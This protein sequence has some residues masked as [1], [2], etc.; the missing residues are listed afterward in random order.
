MGASSTLLDP[1]EGVVTELMPYVNGDA[2]AH[3]HGDVI[4]KEYDT[5]AHSYA[6]YGVKSPASANSTKLMG[7]VWDPMG[8][9]VAAGANGT[10]MVK[11]YHPK[12]KC[13]ATAI[14]L[15]DVIV[16]SATAGACHT[17]AGTDVPSG[18]LGMGAEAKSGTGLTCGVLID[19]K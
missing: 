1:V 9:G 8:L 17:N 7:V 10:L 18:H 11:G 16:T 2:T 15:G 6:N 14:S 5:A 13:T 12:V 3:A 4:T 19:I